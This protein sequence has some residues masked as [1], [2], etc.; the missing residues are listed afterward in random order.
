MVKKNIKKGKSKSL[1]VISLEDGSTAEK[2]EE[3]ANI[4][5]NYFVNIG[6]KIATSVMNQ[7]DSRSNKHFLS[8]LPSPQSSPIFV[9]PISPFKITKIV[10]DLNLGNSAGTDGFSSI[11]VK[12]SLPVV[13]LPLEHIINISLK[14]GVFPSAFKEARIIPLQ[15]GDSPKNPSNYHPFSILSAFL[16]IFEKVIH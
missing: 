4:L 14:I 7:C 5:N 16:K 11:I 1:E 13:I 15:K 9:G 6:K 10:C 3:V 12:E 8:Y 2:S